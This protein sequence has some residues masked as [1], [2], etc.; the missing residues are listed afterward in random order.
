MEYRLGELAATIQAEL[1][2]DAARLIRGLAS[3]ESAA[4]DQIGFIATPSYRRSLASTRAGAVV[5]AAGMAPACPVDCLVVDDP[6]LGFARLS[7]LFERRPPAAPGVHPSAVVSASARV[8]PRASIGAH[9]TIDDDAEVGEGCIVGPCCH[10]GQGSRLGRECRLWANVT[11]YHGVRLGERVL[12]HAGAVIGADGFGFAASASGWEKIAQLGGVEIGDD[13]EIGA[14]TT[15]DR[16]TLGNTVIERGVKIDNQVQL[17][18]NV[19]IGAHSAI[20]GCAGIAGSVRVGR[21]CRIGGGA[22][23]VGHIAI[24]DGVT[25]TPMSLVSRSIPEAG[26]YTSGTG[27]Q[28]ARRWRRAALRFGQLDEMNRRLR[29]LERRMQRDS[30]QPEEGTSG[31]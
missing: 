10:V 3:L 1:R 25:I 21:H 7:R 16:G 6:Y 2:G 29:R 15:I 5:L 18:H 23:L 14:G 13:V 22:G 24:A 20:A 11:V 4:P 17:A 26:T 27:L 8:H 31:C 30:D 19:H 28:P 9:C 12:V